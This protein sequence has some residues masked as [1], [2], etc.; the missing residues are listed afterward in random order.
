MA[1]NWRIFSFADSAFTAAAFKIAH[2]EPKSAT[3][4]KRPGKFVCR[5]IRFF[6]VRIIFGSIF[7]SG[8]AR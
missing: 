7:L 8:L 2:V 1:S 6:V 5:A 4:S 3:T